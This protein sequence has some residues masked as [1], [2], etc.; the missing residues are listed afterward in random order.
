MACY[1]WLHHCHACMWGHGMG[2]VV[3]KGTGG[4][5]KSATVFVLLPIGWG[6]VMGFISNCFSFA[7]IWR[8]KREITIS[9]C[10]FNV[11]QDLNQTVS[12]CADTQCHIWIPN[13]VHHPIS[14]VAA[15]KW[16]FH[17]NK[18][19]TRWNE[20]RRASPRHSV[21]GYFPPKKAHLSPPFHQSSTRTRWS[22]PVGKPLQCEQLSVAP[23]LWLPDSNYSIFTKHNK[24]P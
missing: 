16:L 21:F 9:G 15:T 23:A 18:N 4:R 1:F 11:L 6:E 10:T 20:F 2:E 7:G 22:K 17:W 8:K 24:W 3:V 12:V 14:T 5:E 19:T 13:T